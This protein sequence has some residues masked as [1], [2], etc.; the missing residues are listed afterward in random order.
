M[1]I[2]NAND[3]NIRKKKKKKTEK[4]EFVDCANVKTKK[5]RFNHLN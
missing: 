4:I 2:S 3:E 5:L 1:V